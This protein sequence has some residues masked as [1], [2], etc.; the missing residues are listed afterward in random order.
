MCSI[1]GKADKLEQKIEDLSEDFHDKLH[2]IEDK[3]K[4]SQSVNDQKHE[5]TEETLQEIKDSIQNLEEKFD[6]TIENIFDKLAEVDFN[7]DIFDTFSKKIIFVCRRN[8][9]IFNGMTSEAGETQEKLYKRVRDIIKNELNIQRQVQIL[10]VSR[11]TSGPD[12]LGCR[13]VLVTFQFFKDRFDV[14]ASAR[15]TRI[16]YS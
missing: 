11:V 2:N 5:K 10:G 9:L 16:I 7:R 12:I 3:L 1:I 8:N 13:P 6:R 4:E 14:L 15:F